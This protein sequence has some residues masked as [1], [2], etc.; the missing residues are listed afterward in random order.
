MKLDLFYRFYSLIC[1]YTIVIY[2]KILL[3]L[4][5]VHYRFAIIYIGNIYYILKVIALVLKLDD[6]SSVYS[7][8]YLYI[9]SL[10]FPP[11]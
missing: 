1:Y 8:R 3:Y 5:I 4:R 10:H 6:Y 9:S 7:Q 11:F 2:L